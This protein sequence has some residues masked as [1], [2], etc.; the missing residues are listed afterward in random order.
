ML[1]KKIRDRNQEDKKVT[2]IQEL[3]FV[4]VRIIKQKKKKI[5]SGNRAKE[6]KNEN[7]ANKKKRLMFKD[8]EQDDIVEFFCRRKIMEQELQ[9]SK[10]FLWD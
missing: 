2:G 4:D 8:K 6:K 5:T 7:D 1:N 10:N 3:Q 9:R